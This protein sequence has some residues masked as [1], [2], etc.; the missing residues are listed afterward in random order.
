MRRIP[1]GTRIN[2]GPG[3]F[4]TRGY[5]P[6]NHAWQPKDGWKIIG[7]GM[8]ITTL[9]LVEASLPHHTYD[10][11]GGDYNDFLHAFEVKDLTIDCNLPD[12]PKGSDYTARVVCAAIGVAGRDIRIKRVQAIRFGT[13]TDAGECFVIAAAGAHAHL[14]AAGQY[15][16]NCV[17]EDCVAEQ[18]SEN[19]FRETTVLHFGGGGAPPNWAGLPAYHRSCV[20]RNC[21]VDGAYSNGRNSQRIKVEAISL[22]GGRQYQLTTKTPHGRVANGTFYLNQVYITG[23]STASLI[24]TGPFKVDALGDIHDMDQEHTLRFTISVDLPAPSFNTSIA[25]IGVQFQATSVGGGMAAVVEGN[26]IFNCITG[27]PYHDSYSSIDVIA[28]NNYYFNVLSG[29]GENLA[30]IDALYDNTRIDLA[31]LKY[32]DSIDVDDFFSLAFS[33]YYDNSIGIATT[34]QKHG[35]SEAEVNPLDPADI[36]P[37]GVLISDGGGLDGP[38]YSASTQVL[39]VS[40]DGYTFT[41]PMSGRATLPTSA[42]KYNT[43]D[44]QRPLL[45]LTVTSGVAT[46]TVPHSTPITA[47]EKHGFKTGDAV[48]ISK[49]GPNDSNFNGNH[50]ITAV[51]DSEFRFEVPTGAV[52][53]DAHGYYGRIYQ[54]GHV[55]WETNIVNLTKQSVGFGPPSAI[56]GYAANRRSPWTFRQVLLRDNFVRE[57]EPG[58]VPDGFGIDFSSVENLLLDRN[59]I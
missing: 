4:E 28:R 20:I 13:Q 11:I 3:V 8:G 26:R 31:S 52:A 58:G 18:P 55:D 9:K 30:G 32:D 5:S 17:I 14:E 50:T 48:Y 44:R 47:S 23:Q 33:D 42:A 2:L 25:F 27:G 41:Y 40:L 36:K 19:N 12:Q 37:S 10:A 56:V 39:D 46:A 43:S 53:P 29:P 35:F 51:T 45:D 24:F 59:V 57:L 16:T 49:A 34:Y 15:A 1:A 6:G 54:V 38:L 21:F 22:V 7:S